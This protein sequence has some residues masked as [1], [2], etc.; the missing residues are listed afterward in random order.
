MQYLG[1][2]QKQQKNN[3]TR[4]IHLIQI[5]SYQ[6][7]VLYSLLF[8]SFGMSVISETFPGQ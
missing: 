3:N 4:N 8:V 1:I 6:F 2:N 7:F 5:R